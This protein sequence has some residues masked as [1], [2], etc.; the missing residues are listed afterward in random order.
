MLNRYWITLAMFL[1]ILGF[2]WAGPPPSFKQW[3]IMGFRPVP[4]AVEVP[5]IRFIDESG[6]ARSLSEFRGSVVL[7][8]FW[9]SWCPPCRAEMPS[10]DRLRRALEGTDFVMLPVNA[11]EKEE[12]VKRFTREF[13]I[14]FPVYMDEKAAGA[15]GVGV[16]GL[17]TSLMIDRE[18]R[19]LAVVNGSL[20]WDNAMIIEALGSWARP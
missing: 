10:M 19:V 6:E 18:G 20:E 2:S 13:D 4:K 1:G 7:L 5:D 9:A 16:S 14:E 12:T 17:P 15:A 8:N 3:D 11:G